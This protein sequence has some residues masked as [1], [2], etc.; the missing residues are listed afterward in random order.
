MHLARYEK[1]VRDL[2]LLF[3]GVS[4]NLDDFHPVAERRGDCVQ[5]VCRQ[6]EENFR[7]V[8]GGLKEMIGEAVILFGVEHLQQRRR[9][10]AAKIGGEF[11]DFVEHK[12]GIDSL[13]QL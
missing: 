7:E 11:V 8:I 13:C 10:I 3:L 2:R 9:W 1:L 12:D 6:N 4:W 5:D